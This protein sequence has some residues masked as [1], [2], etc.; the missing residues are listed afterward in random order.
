MLNNRTDAY[1]LLRELGAPD[2]LLRHVQLV[3]EVAD[4]LIHEYEERQLQFDRTLIELGV[5]VHDAGKILHPSEL[6]EP[7]SLHESAGRDLLLAHGVPPEVAQ[8]CVTHAAW[9]AEGTSFEELT[10]AL[11]DKLWKGKREPELELRIV[12]AVAGLQGVDRWDVFPGLDDVFE[13]IAAGGANR[14]MRS[15]CYLREHNLKPSTA[16]AGHREAIRLAVAHHGGENP[17]VFG[18]TVR[19]EDWELSDLDLLIDPTPRLTLITLGTL[20]L[21]LEALLGV[22]VDIVTPNGLPEKIRVRVLAEARPV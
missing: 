22:P 4:D 16:M 3:G 2:R 12:D 5:A 8:C 17:R 6:V 10:V 9:D 14:L 1:R 19:G 18:S 21:E 20:Q 15:R 13:G 7:G 11:S